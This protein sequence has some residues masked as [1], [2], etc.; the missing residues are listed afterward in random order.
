M[1]DKSNVWREIDSPS[2]Q[3]SIRGYLFGYF[4]FKGWMSETQQKLLKINNCK[5]FGELVGAPLI[6]EF[7]D[8][9]NEETFNHFID[10]TFG[11]VKN[12]FGLWGNPIR[13]GPKKIHVYGVDKHLWQPI[14]L[15]I[16]DKHL[17][18]IIPKGTYGNT[19]HRLVS[20]IQTYLDP[21]AKQTNKP[22][23]GS[24]QQTAFSNK[25]TNSGLHFVQPL[26]TFSLG[27]PCKALKI[28]S[29]Q[30]DERGAEAVFVDCDCPHFH[31]SVIRTY[32]LPTSSLRA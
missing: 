6:I 17:I 23:K 5:Y 10:S 4:T 1:E 21:A 25:P 18:A 3:T 27:L 24:L 13:L 29:T 32:G 14:F 7:K 8:P 16:T 31:Q 11:R 28:R 30:C 20:N 2:F 19:V 22:K 15:E 12:R 9:L 26:K